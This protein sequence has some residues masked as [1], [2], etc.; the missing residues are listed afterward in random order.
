MPYRGHPV[1]IPGDCRRNH[2]AKQT[3]TD[4]RF[5]SVGR[6]GWFEDPSRS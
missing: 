6:F 2:T 4:G 3:Y 5:D 1:V